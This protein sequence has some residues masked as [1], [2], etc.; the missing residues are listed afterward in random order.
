MTAG[1]GSASR[2]Y[3][4]LHN[5]VMDRDQHAAQSAYYHLIRAER[6]LHEVISESVRIHAPYTHVPYHQRLDNGIV[7]FVNNDHCLSS[8]RIACRML[9]YLPSGY[10]HLPMAQALWYIPIGLDPWN[11]L[12]GRMPGHYGY[13]AYEPEKHAT[14]PAPEVHVSDQEPLYIEGTP[15]EQ[16]NEWLTLVQIGDATR[17]YR[18][19]LG[20]WESAPE[21]RDDLLAQY[22]FAGLINV[23]DRILNNR[24]Y[25]TGHKSHRARA[26]VELGE[27]IGWEHA[28]HVIYAGV[29]DMA[30]GPNYHQIYEAACQIALYTWEDEPPSSSMSPTPFVLSKDQEYFRNDEPLSPA[31]SE[32]LLR[33]ILRER[34]PAYTNGITTLL[35]DGKGPR[36]ILDLIQIAAARNVLESRVPDAFNMSHHGYQYTNSLAWF[37]DRFDHPHKTKLLYVAADFI[38]QIS[39]YV[40]ELPGNARSI[41][42]P[43]PGADALSGPQILNRLDSAMLRLDM[44]ESLTWAQTYLH[45]DHSRRAMI[46]TLAL[47]AAKFGNDPHNQEIST[48]FLED[49]YRNRSPYR[50]E[51]LLA[52]AHHAAGHR[53]YLNYLESFQR[54]AREWEVASVPFPDALGDDENPAMEDIEEYSGGGVGDIAAPPIVS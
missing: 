30:V 22:V 49:Y 4:A 31:E 45:S 11:Q 17:A 10:E 52:A 48:C 36:H 7:R 33:A 27:R 34:D 2:L 15:E 54:Y 50:D 3:D 18:V 35:R 8:E 19:W 23:Q 51:L 6:P 21:H 47:G 44:E 13:V 26:V 32:A 43:P 24:S 29:P 14:P 38:N 53:K 5:A 42:S 37:Y 16:R 25:T 39:H 28:R 40:Q 41:V 20:I 9:E 46:E 12:L 1:M